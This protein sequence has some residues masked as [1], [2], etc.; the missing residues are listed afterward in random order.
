[1]IFL[2][3]TINSDTKALQACWEMFPKVYQ[4][5]FCVKQKKETHTGLEQLSKCSFF[6]VIFNVK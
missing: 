2:L 3:S 5:F 4:I 1:M 6:K